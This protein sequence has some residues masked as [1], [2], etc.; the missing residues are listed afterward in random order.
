MKHLWTIH[1]LLAAAVILAAGGCAVVSPNEDTVKVVAVEIVQRGLSIDTTPLKDLSART[2]SGPSARSVDPI[3]TFGVVVHVPFEIPTQKQEI[4]EVQRK[5]VEAVR[6]QFEL[7]G[8]RMII[9]EYGADSFSLYPDPLRS[10]VRSNEGKLRDLAVE[11]VRAE[12][13]FWPNK[14]LQQSLVEHIRIDEPQF[15]PTRYGALA[16][17]SGRCSITLDLLGDAYSR[18]CIV[19]EG[20]HGVRTATLSICR[21]GSRLPERDMTI[22]VD[23]RVIRDYLAEGASFRMLSTSVLPGTTALAKARE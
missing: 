11:L 12:G 10:M 1:A 5:D 19:D 16:W 2:S 15:V 6:R 7:H 23:K 3:P 13:L 9:P 17:S 14:A 22:F 20:K 8:A 18:D 4:P 21:R